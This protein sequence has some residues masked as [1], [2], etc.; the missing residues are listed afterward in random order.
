MAL[1]LVILQLKLS[2]VYVSNH[3]TVSY[4]IEIKFMLG[5]VIEDI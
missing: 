1:I 4:I 3:L 2:N 5:I